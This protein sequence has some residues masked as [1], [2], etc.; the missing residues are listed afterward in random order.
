[1][2]T[3]NSKYLVLSIT[4]FYA[5]YGVH[6]EIRGSVE[7]D[8]QE[9]RGM[10]DQCCRSAVEAQARYYNQ[11]HAPVE[12]KVGDQVMLSRSTCDSQGQAGS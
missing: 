1:M 4:S 10:L 9:E 8:V 2:R 12:F 11:R 7:N 3:N 6:P 5:A